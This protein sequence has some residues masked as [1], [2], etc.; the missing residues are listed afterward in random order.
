MREEQ[1]YIFLEGNECCLDADELKRAGIP[2]KIK[3]R[4]ERKHRILVMN[5]KRMGEM[6]GIDPSY[7]GGN[8]NTKYYGTRREQF[9]NRAR[10]KLPEKDKNET[11][12]KIEERGL[13]K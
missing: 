4:L 3:K 8:F 11:I 10:K 2:Y 7:L 1:A 12:S 9:E 13:L 6:F 5:G